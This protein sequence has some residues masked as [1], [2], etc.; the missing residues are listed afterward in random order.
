MLRAG[1]CN[2]VMLA[3]VLV[4]VLVELHHCDTC[5]KVLS[6]P[7]AEFC[8][9]GCFPYNWHRAHQ[10]WKGL[11][12]F[13]LC[14]GLCHLR[15]EQ[16]KKAFAELLF[17]GT[18]GCVRSSRR[19]CWNE[20]TVY[21]KKKKKGS[22]CGQETW[23]DAVRAFAKW[24]QGCCWVSCC[25][26]SLKICSVFILVGVLQADKVQ[27][28]VQSWSSGSHLVLSILSSKQPVTLLY[29]SVIT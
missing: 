15:G 10:T 26:S 16:A 6:Y 3:V 8:S 7:C 29:N 21:W 4:G 22:F 5:G 2:G 1:G 12:L 20:K 24:S 17:N 19:N 9:Y 11:G 23:T 18:S 13:L 25:A 27:L 28:P 14:F